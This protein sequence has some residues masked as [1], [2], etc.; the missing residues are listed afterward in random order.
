MDV[1]VFL[2]QEDR[3]R[4]GEVVEGLEDGM[5]WLWALGAMKEESLFSLFDKLWFAGFDN[6][7]CPRITRLSGHWVSCSHEIQVKYLHFS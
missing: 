6:P 7:C 1:L 5:Q 3:V 4:L 2:V